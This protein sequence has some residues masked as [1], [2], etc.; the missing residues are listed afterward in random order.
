M[1]QRRPAPALLR[2]RL[3]LCRRRVRGRGGRSRLGVRGL[4]RPRLP[5]GRPG[6]ALRG[7]VPRPALAGT[8]RRCA[9]V[10][11]PRQPH[12]AVRRG[13]PRAKPWPR[14]SSLARGR[15]RRAPR[16]RRQALPG[17]P[18]RDERTARAHGRGRGLAYGHRRACLRRVPGRLAGVLGP[19][20][21]GHPR[22]PSGVRGL[23]LLA[24]SLRGRRW[25]CQY[26]P[27]GRPGPGRHACLAGLAGICGRH[28][29][30]SGCLRAHRVRHPVLA[31]R[32]TPRLRGRGRARGAHGGHGPAG[33][34]RA[35]VPVSRGVAGARLGGPGAGPLGPA[36]LEN[37]AHPA[38]GA[39]ARATGR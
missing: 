26:G 38:A 35:H 5:G 20:G 6:V 30:G 13:R 24:R 9:M 18:V 29:S 25:P 7:L 8:L 14:A 15:T 11:A 16:A 27:G 3:C 32:R 39:C 23:R 17:C 2:P 21:A 33:G 22:V 1:V 28:L 31:P 34:G 10:F 36:A 4:L 37:A 12:G 19:R